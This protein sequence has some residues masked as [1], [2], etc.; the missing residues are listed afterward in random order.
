VTGQELARIETA[1][2][3]GRL[4]FSPDGRALAAGGWEGDDKRS[5]GLVRVW[6]AAPDLRGS[7]NEHSKPIR[8]LAVSPDG[9]TLAVGMEEWGGIRV[10][11]LATGRQRV[12]LDTS[13]YEVTALAFHPDNK[14][15]SALAQAR[16]DS[17]AIIW[18][19]TNG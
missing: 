9:G 5:K 2:G 10:W 6:E 1:G 14:T 11:D 7:L 17:K 12:S 16:L 3:V 15:L 18:N 19:V 4:A 13:D 8:S